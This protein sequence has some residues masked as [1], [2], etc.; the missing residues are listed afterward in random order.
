MQAAHNSSAHPH[1]LTK[2]TSE[3]PWLCDACRTPGVTREGRFRCS[4]DCDFDLC[5]SCF[6]RTDI[7]TPIKNT[8]FDAAHGH[9]LAL[10]GQSRWRC[11]SCLRIN[12]RYRYRCTTGCDFDLCG[13]CIAPKSFS[14]P[15]SI[16]SGEEI[17]LSRHSHPIRSCSLKNAWKCDSCHL[18]NQQGRYRCIESC[19]FD[20]CHKCVRLMSAAAK[21][22]DVQHPHMLQ[23]IHNISG[24]CSMCKQTTLLKHE[25]SE[26]CSFRICKFCENHTTNEPAVLHTSHHHRV[27]RSLKLINWMCDLCKQRRSVRYRCHSGCDFDICGD[28]F[29]TQV[30][31]PEPKPEPEPEPTPAPDDTPDS[32]IPECVVCFD[33]MHERWAFFPCGHANCCKECGEDMKQC[34][35]C[36]NPVKGHM[37]IFV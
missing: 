7:S 31:K 18:L 14:K 10:T 29:E 26:G 33:E 30:K 34:P 1:R 3:I 12:R 17:S 20:L 27:K 37:R 16:Y 5:C 11:N 4:C 32:N 22:Q 36:R 35:F 13:Q 8:F 24:K 28:C 21:Y 6:S 15:K 9:E 2:S 23:E 19:D 25:C